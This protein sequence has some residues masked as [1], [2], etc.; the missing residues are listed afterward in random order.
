MT[1]D[2]ANKVKL[3]RTKVH[4]DISG[5]NN[6]QTSSRY[7]VRAS[8]KSRTSNYEDER[9]FLITPEIIGSIPTAQVDTSS[10]YLPDGCKL[11]DP[12][13][14]EPGKVDLLLGIETFFDVISGEK[15]VLSNGLWLQK[16]ELGYIVAGRITP[17]PQLTA[18]S[19]VAIEDLHNAIKRF[20][21]VEN[22]PIVSGGLSLE[23]K[24]VEHH[25]AQTMKRT[26]SGRYQVSLP[27]NSRLSKLGDSASQTRHQYLA[28][29]RSLLK[30][31]AKLQHYNDFMQEMIDLD[32][33]EEITVD[34]N[35]RHY[36]MSHHLIEKPSSTT[37]KFRVVFNASRKT[38][39]KISLNDTLMVGPTIQDDIVTHLIR[40]RLYATALI[41]DISKMYR[42][43][44]IQ[45]QDLLYQLIWWR[46]HP[47]QEVK[48]FALKTVTYGTA[49]A[50]FA[51]TRTLKQLAHDEVTNYPEA[52]QL[53][54]ENFY[55]DDFVKSFPDVETAIS[56]KKQLGEV[57]ASGG[58]PLR[59]W[60]SNVVDLCDEMTIDEEIVS[61]LGIKW[62]K[63]DD[64]ISINFAEIRCQP[65]LSKAGVL[66]EIA[67][68][69]D[70]LG[71][72]TPVVLRAKIFMQQLWK[73]NLTWTEP[74]PE[75]IEGAWLEFRDQLTDV[76]LAP[77][78][79][80]LT[81]HTNRD[82]ILHGFCDASESGYGACIYL[83]TPSSSQLV[84]AKSRVAPLK[85]MTMPR[86]E[87]QAAVLLTSMLQKLLSSIDS[88]PKYVHCW[89]DSEI[90][91][92]RIKSAASKFT[93]FVSVRIA[94]IQEI[95]PPDQ[96]KHVPTGMNPAD[97][98]SRGLSPM[99][100]NNN[101][102]WWQGPEFLL[103]PNLNWPDQVK[104]Q[105][106]N[107]TEA[108][109][110]GEKQLTVATV[111]K[112]S[113]DSTFITESSSHR[114]L[115][116]AVAV[117][118]RFM[119]NTRKSPKFRKTDPVDAQEIK[120]AELRI[121]RIV[122]SEAM[123]HEISCIKGRKPLPPGSPLIKLQ[124]FI[125]EDSILRV[126]G[127]LHHSTLA[128]DSKHQIILPEGHFTDLLL[129]QLHEDNFHCGP[130]MLLSVCRD[131]FWIFKGRSK[132]RYI[133]HHCLVCF[134]NKPILANQLMG[135]L[136]QLRVTPARPFLNV[137]IDFAGPILVRPQPRSKVLVKVYVSVYTCFVT[138]CV[139]LEIV[140]NLSTEAFL[141]C[142]RRFVARRG[143]PLFVSTD[144]ATNFAGAQRELKELR[145]L[146][147][148]QPHI[149]KVKEYVA[150]ER[151][152]W[153]TI[154]PRSP[155]WGGLW[156]SIV[157]RMKYHLRRCTENRI[158][159]PDDLNTLIIQIECILNSRPLTPITENVTD[160]SALT[161]GHFLIG[162]PLNAIPEPS[163]SGAKENRLA[164]W[165]TMQ[166]I[167]SEVWRRF[168]RD[169]FQELQ[170]RAK[171]NIAQTNIRV[172]TLVIIQ[173]DHLPPTKWRLGRVVEVFPGD[174]GKVR[175]VNIRTE[176]GHLTRSVQR[177]APLPIDDNN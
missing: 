43:I 18:T 34:P 120:E 171:W 98:A 15:R 126:G 30:N 82:F 137:G 28:S 65:Q 93:P 177:I 4:T 31:P 148:S 162:S 25:Y 174:D 79:R 94:D 41:A 14:G 89:S 103:K 26:P 23:E 149:Q 64:T 58:F 129:R 159:Y 144:N 95:T 49:S 81:D 112:V 11:A 87:L 72:Y 74:L 163:W 158:F 24:A 147:F 140:Q 77:V 47:S 55:M 39:T 125:D 146:F 45:P 176:H 12:Q 135:N 111:D 114:K 73:Q 102:L 123:H 165:Q 22:H 100:I 119:L 141:Q 59:K 124:P 153:L 75:E 128:Y 60:A 106:F 53:L 62:N 48:S 57:A 29:E 175:V 1:T 122:Q 33:M 151:I 92:F 161:P 110:M 136:P 51:A 169:Y 173:D 13:F 139:H 80:S 42:Q 138:R 54:E 63:F 88:R 116:K 133:V 117:Q 127:R 5:I 76:N 166:L 121:L 96:W 130:Q 36:F 38:T 132:C 69:Y 156:E 71:L 52:C 85:R 66:S 164:Q 170:Q 108:K 6:I 134:R 68:L 113:V 91:I 131:R 21:E 145:D 143:L 37:T 115:I 16:S 2:F 167:L 152:T 109:E 86:L 9:D 78:K 84:M 107:E 160:F 157:K 40:F 150:S 10:L 155:H 118:I 17:S 105:R 50:P 3:P 97:Y 154:P 101:K 104:F 83:V 99:E 142:F 90:T 61:V 172:N 8:F 46:S 27:F 70:P 35:S 168:Q 19:C 67:Q 7:K 56:M 32:H 20:W 44:L